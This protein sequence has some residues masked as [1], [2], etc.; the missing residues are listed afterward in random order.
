MRLIAAMLLAFALIPAPLARAE[1]QALT[2]A[3]AAYERLDRE[4]DPITA[5]F[6]GDRE[7]LHRLPDASRQSE[8][9]RRTALVAL[10]SQVQ[11]IDVRS[12][13]DDE[14]VNRA[15]LIRLLDNNVGSIDFDRGRMP[16]GNDD[17]FFSLGDY[18]ARTTPI[19]SADDAD[20]WLA[21][22]EALPLWYEQNVAN[23]RRGVSTHFTQPRIVNERVLAIV[24][25]QN[26]TLP[27]ALMLPFA[28][29]PNSIPAATQES[30]RTR[31][32]AL[33]N[34]RIMPAHRAFVHFFE[35]EYMP[36]SRRSLAIRSTPNG[37]AYYRY[38]IGYHT[39]TDLTPDQ[40]HALGEQEVARIRAE[41]D[42]VIAETGFHGTF[43][44][45][46]AMLHSDPRFYVT[47]P[48]A[49]LEKS[50]E[51][52]KRADD[53]LPHLFATL[54]R[55]PYGVRPVPADVAEGYTTARY[56]P[57]SPALGQAGGLMINT[58]HLDQ[59]PLYEL[60]ALILHEGVPGHH[61]QIALAQEQGDLPYFRRSASFTA[62]VEGWGLYAESLGDDMGMYRTPYEHFGRLSMEMWRACR[63]VADTGI[64][65]LGWDI[66]HA[67]KCFTD[68]TALAP[69]N[70]Q[71]ELERYISD[72]GQALAY[73]VGE[74][75]FQA[76][77]REASQT[78]GARF[79][80]RRFHDEALSAGA[81]PMDV[82]EARMH[83]WIAA[84]QTAA[85]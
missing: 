72:P 43:A 29:M 55:L 62:F 22:L 49:L 17:G 3:I 77:R 61:L 7:A 51:I 69:H 42:Q 47:T 19:Q 41:M 13:T 12:L 30:Y 21:R 10:R 16:F 74:L 71:T 54:P 14:S 83:A 68:N 25:A 35:T 76:L 33:I 63:L 23:M 53:Q 60:P 70:I 31:A 24:R 4:A 1:N 67:R 36:A 85:H 46:L 81:I 78:L 80:I 5:G 44:E 39:T 79:D 82:L 66:E 48:E 84:Q 56:W 27:T 18:L 2:Q 11:A 64:H 50:S 73:K 6:D 40:I 15:I 32:R 45:F 65:W 9:T 58:T 26:D 59:R 52:A 8:L 28:Q 34:D 20:A 37:A 38:L 75:R 57:G